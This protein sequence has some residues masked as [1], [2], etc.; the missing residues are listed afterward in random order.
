[1]IPLY[2]NITNATT[3]MNNFKNKNIDPNFVTG[4]CDAESSFIVPV[5]KKS[6]LKLGW[7]PSASFQIG[8]DAKD[9]VLLDRIRTYF[10]VG[11]VYK[12]ERNVYR[13]MVRTPKELR[14]I[15]DHFDK[16]PLK[17]QKWADFELFKQ[18]VEILSCKEHLTIEGIQKLIAIKASMNLGLSDGLKAA[19]HD[20]IPVK[21][22][23]V[24]DQQIKDPNWLSGFTSGDGS[25]LVI[26]QKNKTLGYQVWLKFQITQHSKDELLMKSFVSYLGCGRYETSQKDYGNFVCTKFSDIN[27]KIIPFFSKHPIAGIKLLD[28]VD[29]CKAAEIIKAKDHLTEDGVNQIIKIKAG[30]NKG[31]S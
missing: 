21:R 27:E 5:S 4:F 2:I 3:I 24:E 1:V 29:W 23:I 22:P 18:V 13:Y 8:L 16:Y 30:M 28:F 10:G 7:C 19:F 17:T 15:I 25:F 20:T 31:R 12:A 26:I 14:V 9:K 6:K 11:K